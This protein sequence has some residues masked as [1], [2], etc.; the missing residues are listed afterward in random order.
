MTPW[1]SRRAPRA[2][3]RGTSRRSRPGRWR[4]RP[5][6]RRASSLATI[7]SVTTTG[8]RPPG[9][10]T[11]PITRSAS[12]TTCSSV[13]RLEASVV[14]R[15]IRDL[16]DVAEPVDVLVEQDHLG[17]QARRHPRPR[18]SRRC[19]P[20]APPPAPGA[21]RGRR[22]AARRG[23]R[24]GAPGRGRRSTP[25]SAPPPRSSGRGAAASVV[26][27]HRLVGD[28]GRLGRRA[29]RRPPWGR[30]PG[31]GT[32]GRWPGP[33]GTSPQLLL[34]RL[35]DLADQLPARSHTS[36]AEATTPRR[37]PRR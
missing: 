10:S 18:S 1:R 33:R 31:A 35:L 24:G 32:F 15:P 26:E 8:A 21:R 17:L 12:D 3:S 13:P 20:R 16:V 14:I 30:Q 28:A 36:P 5:P 4:C 27:H 6:P 29:A 25:T 19:R 7:S 23:R 34:Q 9:T 22:R 11:A 2:W 37:R